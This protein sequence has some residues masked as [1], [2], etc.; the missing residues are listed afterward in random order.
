MARI[1]ALLTAVVTL[2]AAQAIPNPKYKLYYLDSTHNVCCIGISA[3][4][5][6][7]AHPQKLTS[8]GGYDVYSVSPDNTQ[9]F[10][11]KQIGLKWGDTP[12]YK[13]FLEVRGRLSGRILGALTA[14]P[15]PTADWSSRKKY[16][17]VTVPQEEMIHS[18]VYSLER[19]KIVCDTRD[20][21]SDICEDQAYA[22][23]LE[24]QGEDETSPAWVRILDMRTGQTTNVAQVNFGMPGEA[25]YVWF[26]KTHKFAFIDIKGR[27]CAGEV[28]RGKSGPL[29][30]KS[31]LTKNGNCADLRYIRGKGIYFSQKTGKTTSAYYSNDLNDLRTLNKTAILPAR[32]K[33]S[34]PEA[35][36]KKGRIYSP[37]NRLYAT[38]DPGKPGDVGTVRIYNGSE[39]LLATARGRTPTWSGGSQD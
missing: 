35:Q 32:H 15:T 37:D 39:H 4:G 11:C 13:C 30:K 3:N 14:E 9:V 38:W 22:F 34:F 27:L 1:I 25:Q 16:L 28:R 21:V 33:Q 26:G 7:V 12:V 19:R 18:I 20:W 17:I 24:D 31:M 23:A 2:S 5:G 36:H 8:G 29:V 10:A 6:I